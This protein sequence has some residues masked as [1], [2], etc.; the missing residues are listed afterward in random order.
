[1]RHDLLQ[2]LQQCAAVG[3]CCVCFKMQALQEE[4]KPSV[5]S[6]GGPSYSVGGK[7][8]VKV[9]Q[10]ALDEVGYCTNAQRMSSYMYKTIMYMKA[11]DIV[12]YKYFHSNSFQDYLATVARY[13][14]LAAK[15]DILLT[16]KL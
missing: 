1:M 6:N 3:H 10:K 4:M 9:D 11:T 12:G 14:V 5:F 7:T 16:K 13:L 8:A 15:L 2:L